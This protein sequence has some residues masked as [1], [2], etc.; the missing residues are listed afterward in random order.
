MMLPDQTDLNF[1]PI[2][3]LSAPYFCTIY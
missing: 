3:I 1:R 2:P